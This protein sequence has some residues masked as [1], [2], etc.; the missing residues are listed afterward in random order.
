MLT[1]VDEQ[2]HSMRKHRTSPYFLEEGVRSCKVSST[3]HLLKLPGSLCAFT[4]QLFHEQLMATELNSLQSWVLV[5][6][7]TLIRGLCYLEVPPQANIQF[8]GLY[9]TDKNRT[10]TICPVSLST[11]IYCL[12]CEYHCLILLLEI[13]ED[14]NKKQKKNRSLA[15][16]GL[17]RRWKRWQEEK[18]WSMKTLNACGYLCKRGP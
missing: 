7:R 5:S 10:S 8:K 18:L 6:V 9:I 1:K 16:I 12:V 14:G 3:L 17:K 13:R 11:L 4:W 15:T 2:V